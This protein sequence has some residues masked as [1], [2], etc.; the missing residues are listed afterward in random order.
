MIDRSFGKLIIL[1]EKIDLLI[2]KNDRLLNKA[3]LKIK[4]ELLIKLCDHLLDDLATQNKQ[5]L[6]IEDKIKVYY[7]QL[8]KK[9]QAAPEGGSTEVV[10]IASEL[11]D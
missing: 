4:S 7:T 8:Q 3:T 10:T 2:E 9:V 6:R 11:E 5:S 1:V